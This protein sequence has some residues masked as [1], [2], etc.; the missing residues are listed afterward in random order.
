MGDVAVTSWSEGD[1]S[2]GGLALNSFR[3]FPL[4]FPARVVELTVGTSFVLLTREE[5]LDL[6]AVL[7]RT[8]CDG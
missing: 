2:E 7:Q 4:P 8:A 1:Y 3:V 5:A 6:A